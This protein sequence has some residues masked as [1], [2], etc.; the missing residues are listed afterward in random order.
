[1]GFRL[2]DGILYIKESEVDQVE[3]FE[4]SPEAKE[5]EQSTEAK[6]SKQSTQN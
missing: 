3:E 2:L 5:F 1:L 6:E 4:L